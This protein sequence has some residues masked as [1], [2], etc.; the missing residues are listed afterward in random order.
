MK[1]K[2]K[3]GFTLIEIVVALAAFT[4]VMLAITGILISVINMV[5]INKKTYNTDIASIKVFESLRE[6]RP[7]KLSDPLVLNGSFKGEFDDEIEI[8]EFVADSILDKHWRTSV[9][10]PSVFSDCK[11][12]NNKAYSI[13]V[14]VE[15]KS[16]DG[17]YEIETWVW[18]TNKGESTLINRKTY[19]TPR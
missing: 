16:S 18:D 9:T 8:K 6:N 15:W 19:L 11:S 4:V 12:T 2:K 13:G 5:S 17:L 14:K 7:A 10:N 3:K 1:V